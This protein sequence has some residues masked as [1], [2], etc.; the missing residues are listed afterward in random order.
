MKLLTFVQNGEYRLGIKLEQSV[1]DVQ[2]ALQ[3][4]PS[5]K[6]LPATIHEVI[7]GG[8]EAVELLRAYAE[9]V[10]SLVDNKEAYV[11]DEAALELGPCVTNPNKM[12]CVG[13]NYR[14]HAE[15]TNAAIPEFPILF[16]KFN[17]TLASQGEQ[18]PLPAVSQKVDY[19]AEL[20]IVIGKTAK[21]VSREDALSHVFGYCNVNDL[22]ARDL[23]LRTQQWMLGKICDKFS[24][25]GPYL[26]TADEVGDP[27]KLD[28][29]CM[30]NGEVRQSSNTSD[31]IFYCDE[32]VSYISQ[33]MTLEPGD[34]IFTGTPE[35]VV[36]GYPLE[37]QVYLK[38][39]D[40]VTIQIE[41]LGALTNTMVAD[42]GTPS[43]QV[44]RSGSDNC[45]NA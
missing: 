24:P 36:L 16:N 12:I 7:E 20:V 10:M 42:K 44:L 31:M 14:K 26:V 23:Q 9:S 45:V 3:S 21:Y 6:T 4:V 30:V 17:N 35:G 38:D 40:Q 19:E 13:L 34:I 22:S 11:L 43:E 18:I 5:N 1:L 29:R 39:G 28:I 15:E 2:A 41:K 8:S 37:K 33:H 32:I 25:L 27:N